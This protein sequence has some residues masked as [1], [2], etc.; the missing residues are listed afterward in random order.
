MLQLVNAAVSPTGATWE[1]QQAIH[2]FCRERGELLGKVQTEFRKLNRKVYPRWEEN[3]AGT[4][5]YTPCSDGQSV[6]AIF[7]GGRDDGSNL[8]VCYDLEGRRRWIRK[9]DCGA[10]EHGNHA[11]PVLAGGRLVCVLCN[12]LLA[13][14]AATGK[15]LW[16]YEAKDRGLAA[17]D[18]AS[19]Q[20]AVVNGRS[21]VLAHSIFSLDNGKVLWQCDNGDNMFGGGTMCSTLVAGRDAYFTA[22]ARGSLAHDRLHATELAAKSDGTVGVARLWQMP[23]PVDLRAALSRRPY[24]L[25]PAGGRRALQR[26]HDGPGHGQRRAGRQAALPPP[27]STSTR[28]AT[29]RPMGPAPAPRWA[30]NTSSSRKTRAAWSFSNRGR[31]LARLRSGPVSRL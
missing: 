17:G 30:D 9:L 28:F 5:N 29:A 10:H 8:V 6:Y 2:W 18:G 21:V 7:G 26:Q 25:A 20:V 13:L 4:S 3:D 22:M 12:T 31:Q 16:E 23:G 27:G 19:P 11:S 1:Q 24:C 14:D 15:T